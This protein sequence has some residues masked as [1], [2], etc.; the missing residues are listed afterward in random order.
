MV[1]RGQNPGRAH[2]AAGEEAERQTGWI[3]TGQWLGATAP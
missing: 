1:M 2:D 3:A